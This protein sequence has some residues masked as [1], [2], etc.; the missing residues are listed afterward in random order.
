[1]Q[2]GPIRLNFT[3]CGDHFYQI[4]HQRRVLKWRRARPRRLEKI[5]KAP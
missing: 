1:M 5:P 2:K 3:F 4:A